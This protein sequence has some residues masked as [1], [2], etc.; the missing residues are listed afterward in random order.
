VRLDEEVLEAEDRRAAVTLVVRQIAEP[1]DSRR[2]HREAETRAQ[3]LVVR[4]AREVDDDVRDPFEELGH[5]VAEQPLADDDVGLAARELVTFDVADEVHAREPHQTLVSGGENLASPRRLR[6]HVQQSDPRGRG[7]RDPLRIGRAHH[8]ELDEIFGLAADGRA[9]V[10]KQRQRVLPRR[11]RA[12]GE[13][14]G[15]RRAAD[16]RQRPEAFRTGEHAGRG[17]ARA[18]HRVRPAGGDERGADQER[19][20]LLLPERLARLLRH[21]DR[22]PGVDDR[23]PLRAVGKA[24]EDRPH[25]VPIPDQ[26]AI[27]VR[28][29][30][31]LGDAAHD[32]LRAQL[33]PHR[34]DCDRRHRGR[35]FSRRPRP[36]SRT[37]SVDTSESRR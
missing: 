26:L 3:A 30:R 4:V 6:T 22:A 11:L 36:T 20:V 16:P 31:D 34:V 2:E 15:E 25:T 12:A 19:A 37:G 21:P 28:L 14:G 9:D 13:D 32:L 24:F 35:L 29:P 33:S 10:E 18:D 17:V 27:D 1:P 7:L 5:D 23:E 8:G